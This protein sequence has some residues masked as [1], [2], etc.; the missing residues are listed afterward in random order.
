MPH[1]GENIFY[2]LKQKHTNVALAIEKFMLLCNDCRYASALSMV[3]NSMIDMHVTKTDAYI[4]KY[5][6]GLFDFYFDVVHN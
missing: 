2:S 6:L 1:E 5:K 3:Y 4:N